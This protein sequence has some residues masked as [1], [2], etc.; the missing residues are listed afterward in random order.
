MHALQLGI[1]GSRILVI[2]GIGAERAQSALGRKANHREWTRVVFAVE[3]SGLGW[4]T[5][6]SNILGIVE[7]EADMEGVRRRKSNL[8]IEPENL[9]Q[10]NCLD[11]YVTIVS[12][13]PDLDVRLIP[14]KSKA[15]FEVR[16]GIP[17]SEERAALN[18]EHIKPE[19]WLYA[20]QIE[21]ERIV[22]LAANY[23][24][25]SFWSFGVIRSQ[26]VKSR[27]IWD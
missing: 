24:G 12:V 17:V 20:V 6:A 21:N 15:S 11:A 14:G 3:R 1:A 26:A 10:K 7:P 25:V 27:W 2:V 5:A 9:I 13:L 8:R 19:S 18:R 16:V 4:V 22:Q 23:C